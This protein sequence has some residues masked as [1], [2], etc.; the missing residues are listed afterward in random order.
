MERENPNPD[1][2]QVSSATCKIMTP[3]NP[4]AWC[5]M[6]AGLSPEQDLI[7]FS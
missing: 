6:L 7:K 4:D 1:T 2:A 5:H 3:L